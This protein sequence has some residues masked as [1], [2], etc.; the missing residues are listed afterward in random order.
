M[1][2]FITQYGQHLGEPRY[3]LVMEDAAF[4]LSVKD[5]LRASHAGCP[6]QLQSLMTDHERDLAHQAWEAR[7]PVA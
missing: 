1:A 3:I 6:F 7:D 5:A 2:G 4:P